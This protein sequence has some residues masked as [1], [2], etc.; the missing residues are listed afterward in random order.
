MVFSLAAKMVRM[1]PDL[2]QHVSS[3]R[4]TAKELFCTL[5]GGE[6]PGASADATTAYGL[7]PA[8]GHP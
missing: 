1:S 2:I 6:V 8:A 5:T 4:D 7:S 3:V